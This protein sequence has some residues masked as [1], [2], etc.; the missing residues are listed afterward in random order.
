[1]VGVMWRIIFLCLLV[2]ATLIAD[3]VRTFTSTDGQKI[4][5]SVVNYNPADGKV[6]IRRA[7]N[8]KFTVSYERFSKEDQDY[9]DRWREEYD[10]SFAKLNFM[11]IQVRTSRVVFLLDKSGSMDGRRWEKLVTN[12]EPIIMDLYHPS[13]FNIIAFG[14]TN[15]AF[16]PSMAVASD[17]NK[18]EAVLW[19]KGVYPSGGTNTLGALQ[20]AFS[21][22][23]ME[24]IILLSDGYPSSEPGA[25]YHQVGQWQAERDQPVVIHTVSYMSD[26][27]KEFLRELAKRNAGQS[28]TR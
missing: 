8:Q 16:K 10:R 27:G 3:E 9:L 24:T 2:G 21:D 12:M 26:S 23:K 22:P 19:L 25:I 28:A 13:D 18:R 4:E 14:S 5:A 20:E 15:E 7:D 1:M 6:V 11:G 17:K